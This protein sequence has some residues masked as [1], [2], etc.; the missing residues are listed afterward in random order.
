[1][2]NRKLAVEI[3]ASVTR[4]VLTALD[5][6]ERAAEISSEISPEP[7]DE[8]LEEIAEQHEVAAQAEAVPPPAFN[9]LAGVTEPELPDEPEMSDEEKDDRALIEHLGFHEW[10]DPDAILDALAEKGD[11]LSEFLSRLAKLAADPQ[12]AVKRLVG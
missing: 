6:A 9:P 1:M 5:N 7:A 11:T 4:L 8:R 2:D 10:A 3:G 12:L